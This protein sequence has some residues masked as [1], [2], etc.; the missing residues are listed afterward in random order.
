[1]SKH[2]TPFRPK[3]VQYANFEMFGA[4]SNKRL[5]AITSAQKIQDSSIRDL[6]RQLSKKTTARI[7]AFKQLKLKIPQ[8]QDKEEFL[9]VAE[10]CYSVFETSVSDYTPET[11]TLAI[12]MIAIILNIVVTKYKD[13]LSK[14]A[15][16]VFPTL[17]LLFFDTEKS[18]LEKAKEVLFEH[19]PT[20][21]KRNA[22]I[23]K[24]RDEISDRLRML[25]NELEDA[26]WDQ[27]DESQSNENWGRLSSMGLSL[28]TNLL[29]TCR[30]S[31]DVFHS[32]NPPPI[33]TWLQTKKNLFHP[34]TSP[35]MRAASY[36]YISVIVQAGFLQLHGA[37]EVSSF[38]RAES[39]PLAQEK[40]IRL[41][42]ALLEKN[43][44]KVQEIQQP[45]LESLFLFYQPQKVGLASVIERIKDKD[46]IEKCITKASQSTDINTA[47]ELFDCIFTT[48]GELLPNEFLIDLFQKSVNI[49]T[50]TG[51]NHEFNSNFFAQCSL[52]YFVKIKDDPAAIEILSKADE[53]R[54]A[55]FLSYCDCNRIENWLKT[56]Q[57]IKP[58]TLSMII[59]KAGSEPVR[60]VWSNIKDIPLEEA[61]STRSL[62]EFINLFVNPDE[63]E[64]IITNM[65]QC[66]PELLKSW[67]KDITPF[68]TTELFN[69]AAEL[70]DQDL[71]LIRVLKNIFPDESSLNQIANETTRN[72][73]KKKNNDFD[74]HIFE[75]FTPSNELLDDIIFGDAINIVGP[76][77]TILIPNLV[78]RINDL[79]PTSDQV[80]LADIAAQ[81][82]KTSQIDSISITASPQN[83]P[84]FCFNYWD[85]IGFD[86]MNLPDFCNMLECYLHKICP[87][88]PVFLYTQNNEWQNNSHIFPDELLD[89]IENHNEL[90]NIAQELGLL[91]TLASV[92][93]INNLDFS[94]FDAVDSLVLSAL[95][96]LMPPQNEAVDKESN[97]NEDEKKQ[98]IIVEDDLTKI[99]R[100][101]WNMNVPEF[102]K[103]DDLRGATC[104]LQH[105]LPVVEDFSLFIR[106]ASKYISSNDTL[107]FFLSLRLLSMI[108]NAN[109]PFDVKDVAFNILEQIDRFSPLPESI[110]GEIANAFQIAKFLT[111]EQF[112]PFIFNCIQ[113]IEKENTSETISKIITPLISFFNAWEI[114]DSCFDNK[115]DLDNIQCW[116]FVTHALKE[117]PYKRRI[118]T[119]PLFTDSL[120]PLLNS[121]DIESKEFMMLITTFPSSAMKWITKVPNSKAQPLYKFM[122]KSGT[123]QV[124]KQ[125]AETASKMKLDCTK[126]TTDYQKKSIIAVYVEDSTSV[127]VVLTIS[128]PKV[129]PFKRI[130]VSCEF[131]DEGENCAYKVFAAIDGHQSIEAGIIAWYQFVTYRL[132]EVEPCTI[133]YSYLSEDMK[134]PTIACPTCGQKFHGKC[135]Q[136]WFTQCLKPTCPYCGVAWDEKKRDKSKK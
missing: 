124:F 44:V 129:Y 1:M 113:F 40:L 107:E 22:M 67:N 111:P 99:I 96:S 56:K 36:V 34:R 84:I 65:P 16:D 6:F 18:V 118:E 108:Y 110:I 7:D 114:V 72:H 13:Q 123:M 92:C 60:K 41:I 122:E 125:M 43:K 28:S 9:T 90:A 78:K 62:V 115:L 37:A 61:K 91:L 86:M 69:K 29:I 5:P 3:N 71:M 42:V 130:D 17:L 55:E 79:I 100:C 105:Y 101:E 51:T 106:L 53:T 98:P 10:P 23:S 73:L 82:V 35:Q 133:C 54:A 75:Y 4:T 59:K 46:F 66:L 85:I 45:I 132:R 136:K 48:G 8:I 109:Q 70:L 31:S 50:N 52:Q 64:Y 119:I 83:Y 30:L 80:E 49:N 33:L 128:F 24:L 58:E 126:I 88:M 21:E 14:V 76:K 131:G 97:N 102:P 104:Y 77:D 12:E 93:Y 2:T 11:R 25:F 103:E 94:S 20:K 95:P 117:M 47:N 134:K 120:P 135:L 39:S 127:P 68:K 57:N 63:I 26:K 19:F 74:P 121:L 89:F 15:K 81:F 38:I 27:L 112:N 32:F 116:H 87:F